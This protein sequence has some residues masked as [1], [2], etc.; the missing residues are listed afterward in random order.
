[1]QP[2]KIVAE[3]ERANDTCII[4]STECKSSTCVRKSSYHVVEKK[5]VRK[6][7][8][9]ILFRAQNS[10]NVIISGEEGYKELILKKED[11]EKFTNKNGLSKWLEF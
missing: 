7:E 8:T 1:M 3:V 5:M 6:W 10:Q 4:S 11:M 2:Q 9:S